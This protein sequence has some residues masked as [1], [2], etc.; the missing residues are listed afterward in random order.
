M[1]IPY[2]SLYRMKEDKKG[3][4]QCLKPSKTLCFINSVNTLT[5]THVS[6]DTSMQENLNAP[7]VQTQ[8]VWWHHFQAPPYMFRFQISSRGLLPLDVGW[9]NMG[10]NI[11]WKWIGGST[12]QFIIY[13]VDVFTSKLDASCFLEKFLEPVAQL[14]IS[15]FISITLH[16]GSS[17]TKRPA[18]GCSPMQTLTATTA[19][20][21]LF[22]DRII[23]G[24]KLQ[25]PAA[26]SASYCS[27][28][29]WC[30]QWHQWHQWHST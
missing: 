11:F 17:Y 21:H 18:S 7:Q 10:I 4:F 24:T 5:F 14:Y 6:T 30:S 20:C 1:S 25:L 2:I 23:T 28:Q 12:V 29:R 19:V 15:L 9:R 3:G 8:I 26:M 13:N 16:L 27:Y 22:S